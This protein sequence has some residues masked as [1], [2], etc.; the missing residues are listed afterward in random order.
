MRSGDVHLLCSSKA[1]VELNEVYTFMSKVSPPSI[2]SS[3]VSGTVGAL[4]ALLDYQSPTQDQIHDRN[5][6][7]GMSQV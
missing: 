2:A 1:P 3:R 5:S 4:L 6:N 7:E